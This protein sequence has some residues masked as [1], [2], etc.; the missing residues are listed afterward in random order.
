MEPQGVAA[1]DGEAVTKFLW[2]DS[3][4]IV[5]P[6]V[7][8]F[9]GHADIQTTELETLNKIQ[10]GG[11]FNSFLAVNRCD[12]RHRYGTQ[13]FVHCHDLAKRLQVLKPPFG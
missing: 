10:P 5:E 9:I 3:A 12:C 13:V 1:D 2:L 11:K 4:F 8:D 7:A 6:S